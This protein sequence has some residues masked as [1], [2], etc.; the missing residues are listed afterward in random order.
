MDKKQLKEFEEKLK[1]EKE[2]LEGIM[3]EFASESKDNKGDW[4]TRFPDF[5]A[6]G[7]LDE[8]ADEVEEY[9]SLLPIEKTLET[10]LSNINNALSKLDGDNYGNCEKCGKAIEIERLKI[11]PEARLCSDCN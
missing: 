7:V 3:E 10:K 11:M 9:S 6:E 4:K 2:S 5:K 8:E 1:Q